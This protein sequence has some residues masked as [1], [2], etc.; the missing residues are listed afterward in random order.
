MEKSILNLNKAYD[1]HEDEFNKQI[2][3][4]FDAL[5]EDQQEEIDDSLP[6]ELAIDPQTMSNHYAILSWILSLV[7]QKHTTSFTF[8]VNK[9]KELSIPH[10]TE[11]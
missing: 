2:Q 8:Y 4:S 3:L 1:F 11:E 9:C 6:V 10:Y 5:T 7:A